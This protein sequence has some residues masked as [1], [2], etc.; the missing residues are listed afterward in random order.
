[1]YKARGRHQDQ[2]GGRAQ[3]Q[4]W[5]TPRAVLNPSGGKSHAPLK[6]R[7]PVLWAVEA[8]VVWGTFHHEREEMHTKEAETLAEALSKGAGIFIFGEFTLHSISKRGSPIRYGGE[9]GALD[10]R[11]YAP[12]RRHGISGEEGCG[13]GSPG[14]VTPPPPTGPSSWRGACT[15]TPP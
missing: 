15:P 5:A 6:G 13:E 10:P 2:R 3:A 11:G 7:L 14:S 8:L 12:K 1:M 4:K 9:A